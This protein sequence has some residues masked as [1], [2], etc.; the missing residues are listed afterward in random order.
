M[1]VHLKKRACGV[2]YSILLLTATALTT[3]A[4]LLWTVGLDDGGWV[5]NAANPGDGGG[6]NATFVQEAGSNLLPGDPASPEVDQQADDDYYFAGVYSTA[7]ASV[8]AASGDYVPVGV[9]AANEEAAERAFAGTD[10]DKRYHFNL[11][12]TLQLTNLLSVTFDMVNLD[13]NGSD[14][15]YG[16]EVYVNEVLVQPEI[17]IRPA[18]LNIDY[19]TPQFSLASVNAQ[20]GPGFDNIVR[21]RGINYGAE[22]GGQWMGI[23][24]VQANV[25]PEPSSIALMT[26][27][28]GMGLMAA[29]LRR[30]RGDRKRS[31]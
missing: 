13:G 20:V 30:R 24:Y 5:F 16:V 6:P 17:L 14:D 2:T 18:Q 1:H 28:G 26:L 15:R 22:G 19:T 23:D 11:P 12:G 7:I 25:V 31:S 29:F 8:V 10:N 27:F 4:Q 21:L 3:Q 9:V